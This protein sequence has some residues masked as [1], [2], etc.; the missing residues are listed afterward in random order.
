M[1]G[2]PKSEQS[3]NMKLP[4]SDVLRQAE[5]LLSRILIALDANYDEIQV[6]ACHSHQE[7]KIR[8]VSFPS[9]DLI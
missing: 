2:V 9:I 5:P 4:L 8:S 7:A 3:P 6:R 1:T